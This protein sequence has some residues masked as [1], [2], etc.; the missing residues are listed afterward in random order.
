MSSEQTNLVDQTVEQ[1]HDGSE[2][3]GYTNPRRGSPT[4]A[5]APASGVGCK[6]DGL[7]P[8]E[9]Q[10]H[11]TTSVDNGAEGPYVLAPIQD[12]AKVQ[13]AVARTYV[14]ADAVVDAAHQVL[15]DTLPTFATQHLR[16]SVES[17]GP[18]VDELAG[19]STSLELARDTIS[20]V[21]TGNCISKSLV[22][23]AA[24]AVA[25]AAAQPVDPAR[26]AAAANALGTAVAIT[27]GAELPGPRHVAPAA[28]APL[29]TLPELEARE[30]GGL[31]QLISDVVSFGKKLFS[32]AYDTAAAVCGVAL[33]GPKKIW[34]DVVA[35]YESGR[36]NDMGIIAAKVVLSFLSLGAL[37]FLAYDQLGPKKYTAA[38][39]SGIMGDKTIT[40]QSAL[41]VLQQAATASAGLTLAFGA[42]VAALGFITT[43]STGAA[44]FAQTAMLAVG[45]VRAAERTNPSVLVDGQRVKHPGHPEWH[46]YSANCAGCR[47]YANDIAAGHTPEGSARVGIMEWLADNWLLVAGGLTAAI[48]GYR[49]YRM[50]ERKD[51]ITAKK[52]TPKL[53]QAGQKVA[54]A[55]QKARD[56]ANK[57]YPKV[58]KYRVFLDSPSHTTEVDPER[59]PELLD[60]SLHIISRIEGL[61]DGGDPVVWEDGA[62]RDPVDLYNELYSS[63]EEEEAHEEALERRTGGDRYGSQ[64]VRGQ[65]LDPKCSAYD[66]ATGTDGKVHEAFVAGY[67]G[68]WQCRDPSC[69][70]GLFTSVRRPKP[71]AAGAEKPDCED[72]KCPL[73]GKKDSSE[74]RKV[75]KALLQNRAAYDQISQHGKMFMHWDA[76][77]SDAKKAALRAKWAVQPQAIAAVEIPTVR[78]VKKINSTYHHVCSATAV[79][80][81]LFFPFHCVGASEADKPTHVMIQIGTEV[82]YKGIEHY[83]IYHL[84]GDELAYLQGSSSDFSSLKLGDV[85]ELNSVVHTFLYNDEKGASEFTSGRLHFKNERFCVVASDGND[86]PVPGACGGS[87]HTPN[88]GKKPF[89]VHFA[90][91]GKHQYARMLPKADALAAWSP[92]KWEAGYGGREGAHWK[93][94][95]HPGLPDFPHRS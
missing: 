16:R 86:N 49:I 28:P 90:S 45:L 40:P 46:S 94:I 4:G 32:A 65:C 53:P 92:W 9:V 71:Q 79:Y 31:K 61:V 51:R 39:L 50:E 76:G 23:G 19:V 67:Q 48:V 35:A 95:V 81:R 21:P 91:T 20:I 57:K 47:D 8:D 13:K 69:T 64:A 27:L 1:E 26:S 30:P 84:K 15:S 83:T 74:R 6:A 3:S 63:D 70:I 36:Y 11:I 78:L 2:A 12:F 25:E 7:R 55:Y 82:H 33:V 85:P 22:E 10:V 38:W 37:I 44:K 93:D 43:G 73:Y 59:L 60:N 29:M 42:A 5:A 75:Y 87:Y 54:A 62:G 88:Q 68:D 18:V 89:A 58:A 17:F 77:S 52:L 34:E 56:K 80:G 66:G 14:G 24:R 41:V 72:V